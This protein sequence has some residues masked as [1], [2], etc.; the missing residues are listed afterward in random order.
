MSN[1]A[2]YSTQKST[3]VGW[4]SAGT[5]VAISVSGLLAFVLNLYAFPLHEGK[6]LQAKADLWLEQQRDN[7]LRQNQILAQLNENG[8]TLADLRRKIDEFDKYGSEALRSLVE[9]LKERN[10]R[11]AEF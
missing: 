10:E 4:I 9:S 8:R 5:V 11:A 1:E 3:I 7:R 6:V 2:V